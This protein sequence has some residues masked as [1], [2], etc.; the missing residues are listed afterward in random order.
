MILSPRIRG[1]KNNKTAGVRL[2]ISVALAMVVS[3]NEPNPSAV[4]TA[5]NTPG[6]H[7]M[8]R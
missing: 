6:F 5:K 2:P 7:E 4:D 3:R 8:A 1:A